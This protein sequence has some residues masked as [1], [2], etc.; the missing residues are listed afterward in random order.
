[1]RKIFFISGVVLMTIG[2]LVYIFFFGV[3]SSSGSRIGGYDGTAIPY[4]YIW[5]T[6][7]I[8]LLL[9]GRKLLA[10][11]TEV[12]VDEKMRHQDNERARLMAHGDIIAAD[13][14]KCEVKTN[15]Y[16]QT[17]QVS[18][19]PYGGI[20]DEE[21]TRRVLQSV[22][23]YECIYKGVKTKF[24]SNVLSKERETILFY[25]SSRK[26]ANIYVDLNDP[27]RYFFDLDFL[28]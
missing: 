17:I 3:R 18:T 4:P 9:L 5:G 27:S 7:A 22:V 14:D 23:V 26:T 24:T 8:V 11:D 1:M 10:R 13:L 20:R 12:E 21:V 28:K 15:N 6:A 2:G 25:M 19:Q 16:S